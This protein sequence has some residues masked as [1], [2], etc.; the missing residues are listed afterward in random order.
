T[1]Y[2]GCKNI[3]EQFSQDHDYSFQVMKGE[4]GSQGGMGTML[5]WQL[6]TA[7]KKVQPK[8]VSAYL[9]YCWVYRGKII[10]RTNDHATIGRW[11]SFSSGSGIERLHDF[12]EE[13]VQ[14]DQVEA[15]Q[16][17]AAGA[18]ARSGI[19]FRMPR[20]AQSWDELEQL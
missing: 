9:H 18:E 15:P 3:L 19:V 11:T 6:T 5:G 7:L 14:D 20:L 13:F 4:E 10:I 8:S 1:D 17:S 2:A 16:D 12:S